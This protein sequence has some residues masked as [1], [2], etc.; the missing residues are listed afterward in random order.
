MD[1]FSYLSNADV[2]AID[3]LLIF[4]KCPKIHQRMMGIAIVLSR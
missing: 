4:P 3:Y 2:A 1:R